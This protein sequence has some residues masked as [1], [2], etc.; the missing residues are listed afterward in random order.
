MKRSMLSILIILSTLLNSGCAS[1]F[2][3]DSYY[4]DP[5]AEDA[6][7]SSPNTHNEM[8][9]RALELEKKMIQQHNHSIKQDKYFNDFSNKFEQQIEKMRK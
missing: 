6:Y 2:K 1:L 9:T 8:Q 3:E 5:Y 7:T 4:S